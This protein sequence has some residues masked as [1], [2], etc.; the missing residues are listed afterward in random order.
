MYLIFFNVHLLLSLAE[1]NS[2]RNS[3]SSR[4]R[5]G[6]SGKH[7]SINGTSSKKWPQ[8]ETD[9]LSMD[10]N[11]QEV[12]ERICHK[13]LKSD[14]AGRW[15]MVSR[16]M[17]RGQTSVFT[18]VFIFIALGRKRFAVRQVYGKW[19]GA[20]FQMPLMCEPV[21]VCNAPPNEMSSKLPG[22][23]WNII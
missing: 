21:N 11:A 18:L 13:R 20:H 6:G 17:N 23:L 2:S 19:H 15:V 5:K 10:L 3:S 12:K 1:R 8:L 14:K 7:K 9:D 22:F 4:R 16:Q